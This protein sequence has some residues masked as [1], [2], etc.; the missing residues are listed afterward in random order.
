LIRY[1]LPFFLTPYLVFLSNRLFSQNTFPLHITHIPKVDNTPISNIQ[2]IIQDKYGF[3]WVASQ[4]GLYKYD[5]KNFTL[6]NTYGNKNRITTATHAKDISYDSTTN[7]VWLLTPDG[8]L[9]EIDA[10]TNSVKFKINVNSKNNPSSIIFR[11]FFNT[12]ENIYIAS[13]IGVMLFNKKSKTISTLNLSEANKSTIDFVLPIKN[14]ILVFTKKE[15]VL[16]YRLP[17]KDLIDKI[18]LSKSF[19]ESEVRFNDVFYDGN[20]TIYIATNYGISTL[21]IDNELIKLN[22]N[23]F[24]YIP[25]NLQLHCYAVKKDGN[26]N[27][28]LSSENEVLKINELQQKYSVVKENSSNDKYNW[29]KSVYALYID[30]QNEYIWLGCQDGLAYA[31]NVNAAFTS[32]NRSSND[33]TTIQHAYYLFPINDSIL[34]S[35]AENGLYKVNLN[36]GNIKAIDNTKAYDCIFINPFKKILVSHLKGLQ[37]L[38][39]DKLVSIKSYYPELESLGVFRFNSAIQIND[40]S[41]CF[42]TENYKGIFIWNFINHKVENH[43]KNIG[44]FN[45]QD[46]NTNGVVLLSKNKFAVLSDSY[47]TI[48]DYSTKKS[49]LILISNNKNDKYSLLFDLYKVKNKYY[50]ASYGNGVLILDENFKYQEQIDTKSGLSNNSVYKILPWKDS[51]LFITTNNGLNVFNIFTKK[52]KQYFESDGIHSN[53]FEETSG[54][55]SNNYIFG[56]GVNG[57]TKI[58]PNYLLSNNSTPTL[59][60]TNFLIKLESAKQIDS[61]NILSEKI[62]IPNTA[63]Q[64]IIQFSA[65]NYSNPERT[66]FKYR[67]TEQSNEWIDLGTQNFVTLIGLSP[68]TYHLQVKAANEDDVWCEPKELVLVFKPK[69]YQTLWFKLLVALGISSIVYAFYRYRIAQIKKQHEIRKNIATDLHDDLGSTLNSVK[70]FTNLA[71]SG[72][73]QNESLQQ[74]KQ[75]LNEATLGLRDMIWVLDD[76]LDT[77]DEL[78]TRIK[79]YAIPVG[80]AANIDVQVTC[81]HEAGQLKLSKEEKRNL[82]LICKEAINNAIKYAEATLITVQIKSSGKKLNITITDNGKGFNIDAVKKGYGLKNMEYRAGQ[83]SYRIKPSSQLNYGTTIEIIA[84]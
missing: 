22:N 4:D 77:T 9:N 82:F 13:T 7:I 26:K 69:W 53:A 33:L 19:T 30:N 32:Y 47:L 80:N 74:I 10:T 6:F 79:Q 35:C 68:G 23:P 66:S 56:G 70:V 24:P 16:V 28:W 58:E 12:P 18:I 45:L 62:Y 57:F 75:N 29:L 76:G 8:G 46:E 2:K 27:I 63:L 42:G 1:I 81:T 5:S 20:K 71:I 3:I 72:V 21:E 67:I 52:I 41:I 83:L 84:T 39:N 78:A 48:I 60:Y 73:N 36:N 55:F 54:Y 44:L 15:G 61:T 11:T 65:I 14:K 31:K 43:R 17:Q 59:F 64:S 38:E 37:I 34:Y 49:E 51:L 50:L 40:S 25:A